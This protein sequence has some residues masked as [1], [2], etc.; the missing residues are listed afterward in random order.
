ME[1][2]TLLVKQLE[3]LAKAQSADIVLGARVP[4]AL[5]DRADTPLARLAACAVALLLAQQ[6]RE[7]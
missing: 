4:I 2:G 6:K 7:K 1:T 3:V 5:T